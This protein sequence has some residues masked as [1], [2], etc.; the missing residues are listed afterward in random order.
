M[1]WSRWSWPTRI[2]TGLSLGLGALVA[3]VLF[4]LLVHDTYPNCQ[5]NLKQIGL[6]FLQY[7]QDYDG[8]MPPV[9]VGGTD[10]G[11][12]NALQPYVRYTAVYQCSS[13]S[14]KGQ[15]NPR[16]SKYTDYWYN[17]HLSGRDFHRVDDVGTLL[18]AGEGNDGG[19]LTDARY[20]LFALP[21]Q[22]V[23]ESSSPSHRHFDSANYLFFDGHVKVLKPSAVSISSA[24]NSLAYFE[25]RR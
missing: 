10:Y 3:A 20:S 25:P 17:A 5:S 9:A 2:L 12:A 4:P 8:R 11:W 13:E 1:F 21:A 18:M 19:D 23:A 22:W 7:V 15:P 24:N 14:D 6:G 16:K